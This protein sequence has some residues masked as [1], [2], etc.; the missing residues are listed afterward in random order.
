MHTPDTAERRGGL[1]APATLAWW[2]R[3]GRRAA[4]SGKL[5]FA[6]R[7]W[8]DGPKLAGVRRR[9][10]AALQLPDGAGLTTE[11]RSGSGAGGGHCPVVDMEAKTAT[12]QQEEDQQ[13]NKEQYRQAEPTDIEAQ[14]AK[15][16]QRE[17]RV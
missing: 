7:P 3:R 11:T 4:A 9:L 16:Q 1:R 14:K 12:A 13:Q 17:R 8:P 15:G 6:I 2:T 5:T 10:A